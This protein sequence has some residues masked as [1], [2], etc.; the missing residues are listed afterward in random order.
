MDK[1][2]KNVAVIR[3]LVDELSNNNPINAKTLSLQ[4]KTLVC[5]CFLMEIEP[6]QL[7]VSSFLKGNLSGCEK[8]EFLQQ[9]LS[10]Y[11]DADGNRYKTIAKMLEKEST[12]S[13]YLNS[14]DRII[15]NKNK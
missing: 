15:D 4:C 14:I 9:Y 8:I 11:L 10:L 13:Y 1:M 12:W 5:A 7:P 6:H 2:Q 3:T